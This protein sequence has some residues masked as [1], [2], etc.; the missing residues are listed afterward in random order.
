MANA[1]TR[2]SLL[3]ARF[4]FK[5]GLMLALGALGVVVILQLF[6][7][8]ETMEE[9]MRNCLAYIESGNVRGVMRYLREEEIA[10]LDLDY[11]KLDSLLNGF[12]RVRL[13]GFQ[14]QGEPEVRTGAMSGQAIIRR[15]YRSA[16][17]RKTGFFLIFTQTDA[18]PKL[19]HGTTEIVAAGVATY[20]DDDFVKKVGSPSSFPYKL[21]KALPDL[22]RLELKQVAVPVYH[23]DKYTSFKALSWYEYAQYQRRLWEQA[24]NRSWPF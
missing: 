23:E 24:E 11:R 21:F 2:N 19:Q 10:V 6:R 14:P 12:V 9:A 22:E 3:S 8:E 17:G 5:V 20:P 13:Q 7:R 16:D 18:G 4:P 1:R 15:G